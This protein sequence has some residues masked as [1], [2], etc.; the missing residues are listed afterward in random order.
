[1]DSTPLVAAQ[2]SLWSLNP[3][4]KPCLV[5]LHLSAF[6]FGL[7]VSLASGGRIAN[8]SISRHTGPPNRILHK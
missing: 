5:R 6:F 7:K 1:M 3:L 8:T 2:N 4:S